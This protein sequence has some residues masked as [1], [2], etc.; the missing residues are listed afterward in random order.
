MSTLQARRVA[1]L[2]LRRPDEHPWALEAAFDAV[3]AWLS[4]A[5]YS[6]AYRVWQRRRAPAPAT[7][8]GRGKLLQLRA[9]CDLSGVEAVV[10]D[11]NPT[12][13][14]R[15]NLR[16][17]L[18]RPILDRAVWA[19]PGV[20]PSALARTRA[21]HRRVRRVRGAR[22]VVLM[23]CAGA[24]K[25]TLFAALTRGPLP[26]PSWPPSDRRGRPLVMTRRVR[27]ASGER[28]VLLTDTPGLIW[29][30]ERG[31]WTVPPETAA[32]WR[33]ADLILHVIDAS[34]PEAERRATQVAGLLEGAGT[35]SRAR[36][37]PV[38]TQADRVLGVPRGD[39]AGLMV[40]GRTGVGCDRLIAYLKAPTV[41]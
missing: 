1:V 23:G 25:S 16:R 33:E 14:Q 3:E 4:A 7:Y 5:G 38:R 40:S 17:V 11:G 34:H 22:N 32:E 26:A 35:G 10:V 18:D 6:V 28:T 13:A 31:V 27:G 2:R 41:G 36:V 29:R 37:I 20:A 9:L 39:P 19:P 8:L 12:T 24:G 15:A 30:P 21:L